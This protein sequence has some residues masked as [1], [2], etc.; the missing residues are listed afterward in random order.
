MVSNIQITNDAIQYL[1]DMCGLDAEEAEEHLI[2]AISMCRIEAGESGEDRLRKT[3]Q[4]LLD[5]YDEFGLKEFNRH[6][7]TKDVSGERWLEFLRAFLREGG[8]SKPSDAGNQA[9]F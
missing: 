7:A 3:A 6:F 9:T 4:Q 1:V 8:A 5:Y 2:V